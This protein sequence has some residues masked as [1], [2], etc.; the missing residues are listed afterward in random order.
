MKTKKTRTV[1]VVAWQYSGGA[2]FDWYAAK[3]DADKAF[4]EEKKNE[5][6]PELSVSKWTAYRFSVRVPARMK[7]EEITN[8]IDSNID[9]RCAKVGPS[10]LATHSNGHSCHA[11][12][13]RLIAGDAVRVREQ[14]EYILACGGTCRQI[15]HIL[16]LLN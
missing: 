2:G 12:A 5:A 10:L 6:K 9:E 7:P 1:H 14:A 16:E 11:L 15:E 13:K 3:A 8:L 4:T